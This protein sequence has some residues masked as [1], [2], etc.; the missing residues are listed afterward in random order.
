MSA[1]ERELQGSMR[2]AL[3]SVA[4][5]QFFLSRIEI[6]NCSSYKLHD[7]VILEYT[8]GN[9]RGDSSLDIYCKLKHE[10]QEKKSCTPPDR[11]ELRSNF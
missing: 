9:R 2:A 3:R 10:A 11:Y 8:K 4:F 1:S 5:Q 7:D 6:D